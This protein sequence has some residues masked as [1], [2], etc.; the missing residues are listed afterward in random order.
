[1]CGLCGLAGRVGLC[2]PPGLVGLPGR[3]GV[4]G[5]VRHHDPPD[6]A[7]LLPELD[8]GLEPEL[9][10][11]EL[12][13]EEPELELV[14]ELELPVDEP[15]LV[16]LEP[17]EPEPELVADEPVEAD[18]V[19]EDALVLCV[20]PG[21]ASARAPAVT[22]LAMVTAVVV[23]LTLARPR[24]LAAM[25]WRMPSRGLLLMVSFCG[26]VLGFLCTQLLCC[27]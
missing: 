25:A 11:D 10:P 8:D 20:D 16:E 26:R 17:E 3:G 27:L 1:L 14:P 12:E 5:R 22:T 15:E 2:G 7:W 13:L 18:P 9:K 19:E 6:V 4:P 24:S 23:D 21:R